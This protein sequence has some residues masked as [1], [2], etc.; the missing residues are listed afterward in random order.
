MSRALVFGVFGVLGGCLL[1]NPAYDDGAEGASGSGGVSAAGSS[2]DGP[3]GGA[4]T[5]GVTGTSDGSGTGGDATAAATTGTATGPADTTGT[6]GVGSTGCGG[7]CVCEPGATE[8]CYSGPPGTEGVG[9]CAAGERTCDASGAA[10]G[11]CAGEVTPAMDACGDGLDQDCTGEPDDDVACVDVAC[12]KIDGLVACYSF[13][14]GVMDALRDGS[15]KQHHG[16]MS[17]VKLVPGAA[18]LGQA[19]E[20]G[21]TSLATV[22]EA[23]YLSPEVMTVVAFIRPALTLNATTLFDKENQ[24][25]LFATRSGWSSA[26]SSTTRATA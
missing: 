7:G 26:W 21:G 20:F 8:S 9:T 25:G 15:A 24:F 4:A 5:G 18:G 3:T 10:W 19:G 16:A 6:G 1:A 13:P 14:A 17:G 11:P 2:G 23:D 22:E 12:P